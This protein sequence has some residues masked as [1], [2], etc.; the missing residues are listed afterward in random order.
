MLLSL[1]ILNCWKLLRAKNT[2]PSGNETAKR[3]NVLDWTISSQASLKNDEGSST[4]RSSLKNLSMVKLPRMGWILLL[5]TFPWFST[6]EANMVSLR[7]DNKIFNPIVTSDSIDMMNNFVGSQVSSKMFFNNESVFHNTVSNIFVG[8]SIS[9][10]HN[11][12]SVSG[13]KSGMEGINKFKPIVSGYL[14]YMVRP[15]SNNLSCFFGTQPSSSHVP[16][17]VYRDI[18]TSTIESGDIILLHIDKDKFLGDS[19]LLGNAKHGFTLF[20]ILPELFFGDEKL[21]F[22]I[23]SIS[24][25]HLL[26]RIKV[27]RYSQD[28]QE[29]VRR[30]DK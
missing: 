11:I 25:Y 18:S 1:N 28:L 9:I 30:E 4:R 29:T 7:H 13:S 21:S 22:H 6:V 14:C 15:K 12:A 26:S 16:N 27:L 2:I 3:K 19:I 8:M 24:P 17:Y 5:V 23:D 20:I 10:Q